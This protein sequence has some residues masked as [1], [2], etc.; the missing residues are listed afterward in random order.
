MQCPH[1]EKELP[2]QTCEACGQLALPGAGFCHHCGHELPPAP[3]EERKLLTCATCG[4]A[5]LPAARFCAQC[6][7]AAGHTHG[8]EPE[9]FA[10]GERVACSDGNCIGIIGEDGKCVE[11]GK[12]YTGPAE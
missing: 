7:E 11:C 1:C 12:P 9:G 5:L 10:A 4:Q 6:G 3:G 2:G 8:E